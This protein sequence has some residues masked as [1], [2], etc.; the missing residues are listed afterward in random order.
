MNHCASCGH[1]QR[2]GRRLKFPVVVTTVFVLLVGLA[3][4]Y[5]VLARPTL[6]SAQSIP[7]TRVFK[8]CPVQDCSAYPRPSQIK[9]ITIS[10]LQGYLLFTKAAAA[11][12]AAVR[13]PVIHKPDCEK[14]HWQ[15]NT[16]R[17]QI[18]QDKLVG[19]NGDRFNPAYASVINQVVG[20]ALRRHEIVVLNSQTEQTVGY[21]L[22]EPMPTLATFRFW[23]YFSGLYGTFPRVIFDLF[24]EPRDTSW[25]TW[26]ADFQALVDYTRKQGSVNQI[27]VEGRTWGSTLQGVPI[28][29][30]PGIVYSYHHPGCPHQFQCPV[31]E[32]TWWDAFGSYAARGVPVVNGEFVNFTGG[33]V[34][35]YATETVTKYLQDLHKWHIGVI[36]WSLQPGVMTTGL[37]LGRPITEPQGAGMLVWRDFHGTLGQV[38]V[39]SDK[40]EM[41]EG[42]ANGRFVSRR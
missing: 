36:A 26:R 17:L 32:K 7:A 34:W 24:N 3:S 12:I 16:V 28:L 40:P 29:R 30:G 9:G 18:E 15:G 2:H 19:A 31:T 38:R 5:L 33:Y 39:I 20:T 27:W 4:A 42:K 21:G 37:D 10:S 23:K 6:Q 1:K 41:A 35:A 25:D 13:C 11:Q 22:N 14:H 8:I